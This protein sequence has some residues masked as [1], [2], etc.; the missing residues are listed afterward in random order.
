MLSIISK[1]MGFGSGFLRKVQK[2]SQFHTKM[3]LMKPSVTVGSMAKEKDMM[4][5]LS[6][7]SSL[8]AEKKAYGPRKTSKKWP[9]SKK[10]KE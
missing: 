10:R 6:S 5:I 2:S 8:R 9:D 7:R 3:P 1:S 4:A